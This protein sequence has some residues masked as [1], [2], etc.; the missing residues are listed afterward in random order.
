MDM[1]D[2][3]IGGILLFVVSL[4]FLIPYKEMGDSIE[5]SGYDVNVNKTIISFN[6]KLNSSYQETNQRLNETT[7]IKPTFTSVAESFD[8]LGSLVQSGFDTATKTTSMLEGSTESATDLAT[9]SNIP[10]YFII[11]GL[12]IL[13]LWIIFA[14]IKIIIGR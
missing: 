6:S 11:G 4:A 13:G 10:N 2:L 1:I 5:F 8:R 3:L 12:T 14:L 7:K 9:K